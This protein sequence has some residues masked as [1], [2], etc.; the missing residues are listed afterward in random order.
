MDPRVITEEFPRASDAGG[1]TAR[2]WRAAVGAARASTAWLPLC[3]SWDTAVGPSA[4]DVARCRS[5]ADYSLHPRTP[6]TGGLRTPARRRRRVVDG[7]VDKLLCCGQGAGF[8][9]QRGGQLK[10]LENSRPKGLRG[11]VGRR[12]NF[13]TSENGYHPEATQG[14]RGGRAT[15]LRAGVS[16]PGNRTW[17]VCSGAGQPDLGRVSWTGGGT[18]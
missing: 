13:P 3:R 14:T 18:D 6:R 15:G 9:G 16:G 1:K 4:V 17:G 12:R 2:H 8:G 11:R 10:N 5:S 7:P